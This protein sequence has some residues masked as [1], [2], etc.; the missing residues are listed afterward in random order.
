MMSAM[1]LG[2]F[3]LSNLEPIL[4]DWESF[5]RSIWPKDSRADPI[6]L[7]DSAEQII[8][9]VVNEMAHAQTLDQQSEKSMGRGNGSTESEVL[10]D[11]SVIHAIARVGSGLSLRQLIAEYR[12]LRASVLSQWRA[13]NPTPDLRD[14]ED[15]TRFNEAIDQSLARAVA[16]FTRRLDESRK[17]FLAILGHDLRNPLSAITLCA[18]LAR[19]PQSDAE[20]DELLAQIGTSAHAV[21][22]L[23]A[24]LIDFTTSTLGVQLPMSPAPMSLATLCDEATSELRRA[25]PGREIR[26]V[27]KGNPTG[28]WD[29]HRLRQMASNLLGNAVQHG[30]PGEPVTLT[31]DGTAEHTVDVIV[32]NTGDPIPPEVLPTIFDPLVRGVA[33][34]E[35]RRRPGSIGLGLYIAREIATAHKGTITL[36]S[37]A[38][39]GTTATVRLPR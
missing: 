31:I 4:A 16:S 37:T 10:D 22:H 29:A 6:E 13:S 8:R 38:E 15:V 14:L 23:I 33:S 5:A 26:C 11:A 12:A 18:R 34:V 24:D 1:R 9:A 21:S 20:R 7:R 19:E 2:E 25:N 17:M 28:N 30:A 39:E 32:H 36:T 3:I 27:V 35:K